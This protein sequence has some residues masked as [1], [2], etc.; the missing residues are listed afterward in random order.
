MQ[1]HDDDAV[2]DMNDLKGDQIIAK[3][4][5]VKKTLDAEGLAAEFVAPRLWEDERTI[6]GGYTSNDPACR[7][8]AKERSR[9]CIDIANALDKPAV[10]KLVGQRDYEEL[11]IL[12]INHLMGK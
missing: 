6:D 8:F 11:E 4:G 3:A 7:E 12:I 5:Q 9:R 1:F 2:P 10:E